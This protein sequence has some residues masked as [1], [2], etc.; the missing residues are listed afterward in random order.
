MA[1]VRTSRST[2]A[3]V[4][5]VLGALATAEAWFAGLG[6]EPAW[7]R[8]A[9]TL[10]QEYARALSEG[11]PYLLV[12]ADPSTPPALRAEQN[13]DLLFDASQYRGHYYMYFGMPPYLAV[14]VPWR[15]LTGT[16]LT[17]AAAVALFSV[18]GQ[19]AYAALALLIGRRLGAGPVAVG[20]AF[21]ALVA[22]GGTWPLLGRPAVYEIENAA[23]YACLGWCLFLVARVELLGAGRPALAGAA[24]LAGL[25][26][27]CRPNYFPA[28]AVVAAYVALRA[29]ARPGIPR[30]GARVLAA[31]APLALVGAGLAWWNAVRF[32]SPWDFGL[33]QFSG[34]NH[35]SGFLVTSLGNAPYYAH[36]YLLGGARL[37]RYFPFIEGESPGPFARAA[38]QQASNQVYGLLL[39]SPLAWWALRLSPARK[40]GLGPLARVLLLCGLG[41]L[42][43]LL[44]IK[45]SCYRYPAD[46][47]GPLSLLGGL[48]ALGAAAAGRRPRAATAALVLTAAWSGGWAVLEACSVRAEAGGGA[49]PEMRRLGEA[50]NTGV[51]LQE[52]LTGGGPRAIALELSFPTDKNSRVEP[53]LVTGV[54]GAENFLYAYYAGPGKLQFGLEVM[55]RGGPLGAPVSV[56]YRARHRLDIFLGSFLPPDGHPLYD[57]MGPDAVERAREAVRVRLDGGVVLERSLPLHPD[58]ARVFLGESPDDPAFGRVFTGRIYAVNRPPI[59][60][61]R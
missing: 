30:R 23:A 61:L 3:A 12:P 4:L 20:L 34:T 57:G 48:G 25:A 56:D 47:A 36:R 43:Y 32:G 39:F 1:D 45:F 22:C 16:L 28:V 35:Q 7:T 42:L 15:L 52:K 53:L 14:L 49:D 21:A 2:L 33:K 38:G 54:P 10:D 44:V 31:L 9:V 37:G 6:R 11:Y 60:S 40:A 29:G 17:P 18:L 55:G 5:L 24:G 26:L 59:R 8:A 41:N 19:A 27:G 13:P 50:F 51:F 58:R 46:F